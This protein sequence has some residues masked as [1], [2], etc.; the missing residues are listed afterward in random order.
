MLS[1]AVKNTA[2]N[3]KVSFITFVLILRLT[4]LLRIILLNDLKQKKRNG[5][6]KQKARLCIQNVSC[7]FLS[8]TWQLEEEG[9]LRVVYDFLLFPVISGYRITS[10]VIRWCFILSLMRF[11]HF[12]LLRHRI[13]NGHRFAFI[14]HKLPNN[15]SHCIWSSAGD[16]LSH[17]KYTTL[18]H[19][20]FRKDTPK[21]FPRQHFWITCSLHMSVLS[22]VH[23]LDP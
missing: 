9:I 10:M 11:L 18:F 21:F 17:C 5:G 23:V 12:F 2:V 7:I 13:L 8:F 20:W 1:F 14:Q 4:F 3:I 22:K 19:R 16:C 15:Q 6:F